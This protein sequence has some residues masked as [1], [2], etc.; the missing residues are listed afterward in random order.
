MN[1]KEKLQSI[2]QN[3]WVD[4]VYG[5]IESYEFEEVMGE[6]EIENGILY[7]YLDQM[8]FDR[9]GVHA[10]GREFWDEE[11][12]QWWNEYEDGVGRR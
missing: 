12:Q 4:V 6:Y 9:D 10:T 3:L 8:P 2:R 5:S 1:G 7:H 11:S